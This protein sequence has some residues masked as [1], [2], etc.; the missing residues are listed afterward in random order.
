MGDWFI[1]HQAEDGSWS[2]SAFFV[3]EP[4]VVHKMLNR[5]TCDGSQRHPVGARCSPGAPRDHVT[6]DPAVLSVVDM[7]SVLASSHRG[8]M[9]TLR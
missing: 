4:T 9:G 3:P 5:R 8:G 2:P 7:M 6:G 1:A